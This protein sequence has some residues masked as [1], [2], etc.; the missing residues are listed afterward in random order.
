MNERSVSRHAWQ[1]R[2]T[3]PH[4]N[5]YLLVLGGELQVFPKAPGIGTP[6]WTQR[7]GH[8]RAGTDGNDLDILQG[9]HSLRPIHGRRGRIKVQRAHHHPLTPFSC[10]QAA[11][12]QAPAQRVQGSPFLVFHIAV[13]QA[14]AVTAATSEDLSLVIEPH[15]MVLRNGKGDHAWAPK[16]SHCGFEDARV[17]AT[18][19]E[20]GPGE[21]DG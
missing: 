10:S 15:N 4:G 19:S 20:L 14:A 17:T 2:A 6:V 13:T 7:K 16:I 12:S 3:L 18:N 9:L 21:W 5:P 11:E 8:S 1:G